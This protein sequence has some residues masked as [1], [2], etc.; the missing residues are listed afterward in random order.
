MD[1]PVRLF[2]DHVQHPFVRGQREPAVGQVG[3]DPERAVERAAQGRYVPGV[4]H[5][6]ICE[7]WA[8]KYMNGSPVRLHAWNASRADSIGCG[9]FTSITTCIG[10]P[11]ACTLCGSLVRSSTRVILGASSEGGA[12]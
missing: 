1:L 2:R 10:F 5:I 11:L 9:V 4:R 12:V 8:Q 6:G 7:S 3:R